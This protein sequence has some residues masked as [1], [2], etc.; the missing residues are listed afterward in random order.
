MPALL[1]EVSAFGHGL[2]KF[3]AVN[4]PDP[5][6]FCLCLNAST[7]SGRCCNH[8]RFFYEIGAIISVSIPSGVT[9]LGSFRYASRTGPVIVMPFC[10]IQAKSWL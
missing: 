5:S 4:M 7:L 8:V 9:V 10:A 6:T 2:A 1:P 3:L